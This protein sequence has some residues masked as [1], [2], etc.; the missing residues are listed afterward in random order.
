MEDGGK[1]L[2]Y[3]ENS[4]LTEQVVG[5]VQRICLDFGLSFSL[6]EMESRDWNAS[7][8]PIL[9]RYLYKIFVQ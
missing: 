3:I 7:G 8:N 9:I 5:E 2:A 4:Q 6:V 1:L